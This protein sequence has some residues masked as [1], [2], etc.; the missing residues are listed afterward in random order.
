M[1]STTWKQKFIDLISLDGKITTTNTISI[2]KTNIDDGTDTNRNITNFV[3]TPADQKINKLV[4]HGNN[5]KFENKEDKIFNDQE[6]ERSKN[7]IKE[8]ESSQ[9]HDIDCVEFLD[10]LDFNDAAIDDDYIK[11]LDETT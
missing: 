4:Q 5:K 9:L 10:T 1:I 11:Y 8:K 7:D 3:V 2:R 6:L